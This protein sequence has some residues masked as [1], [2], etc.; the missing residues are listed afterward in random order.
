MTVYYLCPDLDRPSGGVRV[1]Y[2]HVDVLNKNGIDA[3]VVH[4]RIGYRCEWF[5]NDTR[6]T[7][8]SRQSAHGSGELR[9]HLARRLGQRLGRSF[10]QTVF[11]EM[12][13]HP[14]FDLQD[15]DFVV[16]PE[17]LGPRL[18]DIAPGIRKLIFNQGTY[19]SFFG[20]PDD[21]RELDFPFRHPDVRGVL[22]I[23]ED[24]DRQIRYAFPEVKTHR[25]RW[26]I[27]PDLFHPGGVKARRVA[28]MPRRAAEDAR[29]V[30]NVLAARGRLN[31]YEIVRVE[32]L[33]EA[34][35]AAALR[36]TQ[37]FLSLGYHEGLPRPPAEAMA[38]GAIVVGY[39]GFGGRE[40]M[41]PDVSYPVP[42]G[43]LAA[44][45]RALEEVLDKLE[46]SPAEM[47]AR[48]RRASRFIQELYSPEREERE[49]VGVWE[50]QLGQGG[51]T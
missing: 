39:D 47:E 35:V 21:A 24:A 46:H 5:K 33:D 11:Q 13:D 10:P 6:V 30:L 48:A 22:V 15:D 14:A 36:E 40:Y 20:Y 38:C 17:L 28:F 12:P 19:L 29:Y 8:W 16:I 34:G 37:V 26:S 18:T 32:G 27:D 9:R 2:R 42:A 44:F 51:A 4:E 43:D 23:S 3:F 45:A 41:R 1:I 25:V 7:S 31:G 49:V 50:G